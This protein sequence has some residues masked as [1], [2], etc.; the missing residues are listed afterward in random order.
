[1]P[2]DYPRTYRIAEQIKREIALILQR[3]LKDP[4]L[5]G[6]ISISAVEVSGDLSFAKVYVSI[7]GSEEAIRDAMTILK[8]AKK[9][10][11]SLLARRLSLR[12]MP[13][14][15]FIYDNSITEG[16]RLINL[17]DKALADDELQHTEDED[18]NNAT[19][20]KNSDNSNVNDDSE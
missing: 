4:R 3:E 18:K 1:M 2:K 9:F 6:F 17:I 14:L 11:R 20:S 13:E 16:S 12:I 19:P 7:L 8:N 15:N 10:I 5:K